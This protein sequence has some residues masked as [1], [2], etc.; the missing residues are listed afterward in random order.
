MRTLTDMSAAVPKVHGFTQAF[1]SK[2]KILDAFVT[3]VH[4]ITIKA[5]T[6]KPI[7]CNGMFKEVPLH[8]L[9]RRNTF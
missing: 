9:I 6:H 5:V 1:V 7:C 3:S 4:E 8:A 2:L